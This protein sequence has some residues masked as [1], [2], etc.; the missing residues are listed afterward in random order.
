LTI[1]LIDPSKLS[2][3]NIHKV[4]IMA[5]DVWAEGTGE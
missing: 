1:E 3:E 4:H 5:N 2:M